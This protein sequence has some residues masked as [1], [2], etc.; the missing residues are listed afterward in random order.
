MN[1]DDAMVA[2]MRWKFRLTDYVAGKSAE[3]L[4]PKVVCRD[5]HCELGK[6]IHGEAA[7]RADPDLE[8]LRREHAAFHTHASGVIEAF[9][10]TKRLEAETILAGP[11]TVA[12]TKV[13]ML[14]KRIR[15]R[16]A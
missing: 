5:D 16:A 4:D 3:R 15:E 13:I 10:A 14:I 11:Y 9:I 8:E 12:S 6:W 1:F 2:H 7:N